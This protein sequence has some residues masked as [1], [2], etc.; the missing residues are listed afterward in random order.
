MKK[1]YLLICLLVAA[2][3][4]QATFV[5]N[6]SLLYNIIQTNSNL[7]LGVLGT[8][9]VVQAANSRTSQAFQFVPVV[10]KTDTYYIQNQDG[11]YLNKKTTVDWDYWDVI[12]ETAINGANSE[13]TITGEASS[14]RLMCGAN[15][16]YLASDAITNGSPLYCDK[17][18]DNVRGTFTVIEAVV[19]REVFEIADRNLGIQVEKDVQPYPVTITCTGVYEN[20]Y[21]KPTTGFTVNKTTLTPE[22]FLANGGKQ[23]I[24]VSTT[25]A[26]GTKGFV[27]F[28]VGTGDQET[29]FDTLWVSSVAKQKRYYIANTSSDG[30][31]IGNHSTLDVPAL[32]DNLGATTQKFILRPVHPTLNDSLYYMIQDVTYR[33]VMKAFSSPWDVEFSSSCDEAMWKLAPQANG[34]CYFTNFVT[35]KVLGTDGITV[36][37]RLYD[38]KS[39]TPAPT[40]KPFSEWKLIDTDSLSVFGVFR[41]AE[42]NQV[43][44]IEKDFQSY[45]INITTSGV[46]ETI[47]AT[48]TTGYTLDKST[49]TTA[50]VLLAAG[51]LKVRISCTAPLGTT[52]HVYFSRTSNTIPFDTL[53][54]TSVAVLPRYYILNTSSNGLVIGNDS[55]KTVPALTEN[56]TDI[57]QKFIVRPLHAAINDS[58]YYLIQDGDYRL[59]AKDKGNA[60]STTYAAVTSNETTWKIIPMANGTVSLENYVTKKALGSD[61]ITVNS[62]LWDD[63]TFTAAPTVAPY[64]EWM[65]VDM[66]G[67][68]LKKVQGSNLGVIAKDGIVQIQGTQANEQIK[69]Y[70]L[71]GRLVQ[72][73]KADS[74]ITSIKLNPGFYFVQVGSKTIKV[75]L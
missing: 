71:Y 47:T 57:T 3:T 52:G 39:F 28:A 24:Q 44:A 2:F 65:L 14:F 4:A 32:T 53:T 59:L 9:P 40:A 73:G 27:Y 64:C 7:T 45:P 55:T 30:L 62:W 12:Y 10:G 25:A 43:I 33:M 72:E 1:L 34:T 41:I 63:K 36:D 58:L 11:Q 18:V 31:V 23:Q 15:S 54:M 13:W 75:V 67:S 74:N 8:Q 51:K 48:S 49:F 66:N 20:I 60:W 16:L 56:K 50:D 42:K 35:G 69:V 70:N 46:K 19:V 21:A 38:D 68:A 5:P 17:A 22:E 37:S 29:V 61:A 6:S 26:P